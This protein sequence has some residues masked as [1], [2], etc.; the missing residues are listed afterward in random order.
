[1]MKNATIIT[2]TSAAV[3]TAGLIRTAK[4]LAAQAWGIFVAHQY[5]DPF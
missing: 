5:S 3:L 1:M 4:R 2:L